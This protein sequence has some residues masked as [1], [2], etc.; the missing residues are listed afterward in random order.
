VLSSQLPPLLSEGQTYVSSRRLHFQSG[1]PA[2]GIDFKGLA[3]GS[4]A[5][6][7]LSP[8]HEFENRLSGAE[9]TL[10]HFFADINIRL[11]SGW[12][13]HIV[14]M[15]D[16]C[17]YEYNLYVIIHVFCNLQL[18]IIMLTIRIHLYTLRP[19]RQDS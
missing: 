17:T 3:D 12:R 4:P 8:Q 14:Q 7:K 9:F 11:L 6:S 2:L 13:R 5:G 19:V 18:I 1:C 15:A 16:E 10:S